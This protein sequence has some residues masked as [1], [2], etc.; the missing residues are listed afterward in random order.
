[1]EYKS[2][3]ILKHWLLMDG[4][5][6][7]ALIKTLVTHRR[8]IS[9]TEI[10]ELSEQLHTKKGYFIEL[11]VTDNNRQTNSTFINIDI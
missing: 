11:V 9:A 5:S 6:V 3:P 8:T 1:M 7:S 4:I 10:F 2:L